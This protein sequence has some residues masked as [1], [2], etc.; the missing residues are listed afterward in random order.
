MAK[1]RRLRIE[2]LQRISED[3]IP[4]RTVQTG[5]QWEE[6]FKSIQTGEVLVFQPDQVASTTVR[7]ALRRLQKKGKFKKLHSTS[8]KIGEKKYVT[9]VVNPSKEG[10]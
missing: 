7:T 10:E 3:E 1:K 5:I 9:Y 4:E 8:R 2:D 6:I